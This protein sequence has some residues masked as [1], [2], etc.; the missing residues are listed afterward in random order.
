MTMIGVTVA[1]PCTTLQWGHGPEAV[2]DTTRSEST[3]S[4]GSFNGATALRPW[5]TI[6]IRC[7]G[8][9]AWSLQWGHGPE[10]VDDA[11]GTARSRGTGSR[12][13]GATA[14]RPWMTWPRG[15]APGRP[16]GFNG[17]TALRPWMT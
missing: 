17:A 3:G 16:R 8:L 10:A 5:M 7:T 2:D 9:R 12:F 11:P 14:L 15:E 1:L 13:N 6:G 4:S